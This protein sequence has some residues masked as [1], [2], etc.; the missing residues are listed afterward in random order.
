MSGTLNKFDK[1]VEKKD[2]DCV[3]KILKNVD[4]DDISIEAILKQIKLFDGDDTT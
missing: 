3:V 1:A 2:I 4:L